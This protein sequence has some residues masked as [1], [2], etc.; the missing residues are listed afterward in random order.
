MA[1]MGSPN[2]LRCKHAMFANFMNKPE[3]TAAI[4]FGIGCYRFFAA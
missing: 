3:L 1:W 2:T 4:G